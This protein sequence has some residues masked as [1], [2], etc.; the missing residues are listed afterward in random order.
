MAD[1]TNRHINEMGPRADLPTVGRVRG[2]HARR[3]NWFTRAPYVCIYGTFAM[4]RKKP[5]G[6]NNSKWHS[7]ELGPSLQR[8][9]VPQVR[10]RESINIIFVDVFINQLL[11]VY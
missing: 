6:E 1:G 9:E 7:M 3:F 11:F 5:R 10:A 2:V 4:I 8:K